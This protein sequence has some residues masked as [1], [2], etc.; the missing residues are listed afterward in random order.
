MPQ[1][2]SLNS[3]SVVSIRLGV[4]FLVSAYVYFLTLC[5]REAKALARLCICACWSESSLLVDAIVTKIMC[6]VSHVL[7]FCLFFYYERCVKCDV[8]MAS[9]KADLGLGLSTH[10]LVTD[11][12]VNVYIGNTLS[13]LSFKN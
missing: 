8:G 9:V 11:I 3:H 6:A 5:V 12:Q 2:L 7:N 13:R 4:L 1:K 10:G